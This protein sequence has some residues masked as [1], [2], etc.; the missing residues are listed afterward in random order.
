MG[1]S[2]D[3]LRRLLAAAA[4]H[5]PRSAA[6]TPLLVLNGLRISEA[7]STDVRDYSYDRGHRVLR[8]I[9][10][11]AK[12]ARV[13]LAPPVVRAVDAYLDGRGPPGRS[14]WPPTA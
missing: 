1:L 7:L 2:A 8:I 4:A 11:G 9:R 6:L 10:K 14:S 12:P 5:S 3:E 13:P